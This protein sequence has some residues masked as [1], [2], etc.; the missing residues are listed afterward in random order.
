MPAMCEKLI[1]GS[2]FQEKTKVE[3]TVFNLIR[4]LCALLFQNS[5]HSFEFENSVEPE[6]KVNMIK[7]TVH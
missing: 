6:S 4:V 3:N 1:S 7:F 5:T 2:I